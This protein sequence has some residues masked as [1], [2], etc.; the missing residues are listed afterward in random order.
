MAAGP[1]A[2]PCGSVAVPRAGRGGGCHG[3]RNRSMYLIRTG[4]ASCRPGAS[5]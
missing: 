2:P 1:R 5:A 4:L 3:I